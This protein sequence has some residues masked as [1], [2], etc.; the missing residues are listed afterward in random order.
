MNYTAGTTNNQNLLDYPFSVCSTDDIILTLMDNDV[1]KLNM[2]QAA[3]MLYRSTTVEA[4]FQCRNDEDLRPYI[5]ELRQQIETFDRKAF[6]QD[7]IFYLGT[8]SH[9][10]KEFL[11]YLRIYRLDPKCIHFTE[12][13]GKPD[14]R[15]RGTWLG[16][17]LWEIIILQLISEIRN[18]HRYPDVRMTDV[19][20]RLFEKI[21]WFKG[22]KEKHP[23]LEK[24]KFADFGTRRRFS[25]RVQ[26]VVVDTLNHELKE[27]FVGTSNINLARKFNLTPIGTQ[28]HEWFQAHQ[29]LGFRLKDSQKAALEAWVQVY[30]GELGIALTDCICMD[31]FI[32]DF[33]LYF[34][35][36]FD[37]LR[38]DSG[39]PFEWAR[40]AI[41]MYEDMG[42]DPKTKT[43]IFSDGLDLELAVKLF[44]EFHDQ[45]DV[46]FGIGTNLT[47]DI[48]GVKAMNIVMKLVRVNGEPVVKLSDSPGKSMCEDQYYVDYV[49]EVFNYPY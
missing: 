24:F 33:D 42:I 18:R 47:C 23:E 30:R 7:E 34:G 2:L 16:Y 22:M 19:R 11:D 4:K 14:I 12:V 6:T 32:N 27:H 15:Y 29:Q 36:L 20:K 31:S 48:E 46:S 8:L 17:F 1:Y 13:D 38:H 37:G 40:K 9:M 35:K 28:A 41:K 39:C 45:I 10:K 5:G 49:K 26:E 3:F 21:N 25:G 43:L 44:L